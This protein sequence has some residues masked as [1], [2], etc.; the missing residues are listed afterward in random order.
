MKLS[1]FSG[2]RPIDGLLKVGNTAPL[3]A[4]LEDAT[5]F[6]HRVGQL[7]AQLDCDAARFFTVN[8]FASF[9]GQ[10][11]CR[12]VPAISRRDQHGVDV[13][14]VEKLTEIMVQFAAGVAV[15]IIDQFLAC[16]SARRL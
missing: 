9:G 16:V 14:P 3:S 8:I 15:V 1:E 7:L 11:R 10:D 4:R 2:V 5:M 12:S 13:F 6:V